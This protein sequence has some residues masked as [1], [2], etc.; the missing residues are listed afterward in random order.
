MVCHSLSGVVMN[1]LHR[2][3]LW[4][5]VTWLEAG[6]RS[7]RGDHEDVPHIIQRTQKRLLQLGQ[8]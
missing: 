8:L 5:D 6:L 2:F 7:V 4:A 1:W 3:W